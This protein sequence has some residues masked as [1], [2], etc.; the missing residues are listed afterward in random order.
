MYSAN[1][2]TKRIEFRCPDP[3]CNPYLGFA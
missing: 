2:K 1:P 3:T